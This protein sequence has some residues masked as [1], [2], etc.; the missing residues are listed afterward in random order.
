[1]GPFADNNLLLILIELYGVLF[2][3]KTD[4][5]SSLRAGSGTVRLVTG[6]EKI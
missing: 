6:W 4:I 1:M 2:F 5:L 3:L